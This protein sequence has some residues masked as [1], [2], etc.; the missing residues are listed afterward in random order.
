METVVRR[1]GGRRSLLGKL[2]LAVF[3]LFNVAMLIWLLSYWGSVGGNLFGASDA[4]RMG[5]AI[6]TTVTTSIILAIWALGALLTGLLA[7]ATRKRDAYVVVEDPPPQSHT[8]P[9][10]GVE[11]DQGDAD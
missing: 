7:M 10:A 4:E 1:N 5:S 9:R 8:Q 2:F 6:D 3:G 11:K